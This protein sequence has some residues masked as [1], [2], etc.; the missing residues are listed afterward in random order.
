VDP[1]GRVGS[2]A[3]ST[4]LFGTHLQGLIENQPLVVGNSLL[5]STE[6]NFAYGLNAATGAVLWTKSFGTPF[7]SR[8]LGCADLPSA[9]VTGPPVVDTATNTEFTLAKT[10]VSATS[11]PGADWVHVLDVAAGQER[12][13]FPVQMAG[14]ASNDRHHSFNASYQLQ[15]PGLVLLDGVVYRAFGG[16]CDLP[17]THGWITGVSVGGKITTL[18]SDEAGEDAGSQ[19]LGGPGAPSALRSD[20]PGQRIFASGNG[21]LPNGS[22]RPD[23]RIWR[24][25]SARRVTCLS[26]MPTTWVATRKGQ[27]A[28]TT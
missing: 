9:G 15:R 7:S 17:P 25:R 28:A 13:G 20:G 19:G 14:V 26:S 2:G 1:S 6:A 22:A 18:W 12:T 24:S 21:D 11:G 3:S 4:T 27:P 10:Y 16:R 8:A 5:V 23:I